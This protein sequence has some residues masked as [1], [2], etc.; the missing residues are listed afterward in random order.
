MNK[1]ISV[2]SDANEKVINNM[3]VDGAGPTP[4]FNMRLAIVNKWDA[5]T[6]TLHRY[7]LWFLIAMLLGAG[8]G[9]KGANL[10]LKYRVNEIIKVQGFLWDKT[11][12][13]VTPRP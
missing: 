13:N 10:Y 7:G 2:G 8:A 11:V 4:R 9:I 5:I 3:N 12:Y 1:D 6:N